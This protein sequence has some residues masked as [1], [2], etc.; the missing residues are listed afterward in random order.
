LAGDETQ[1]ALRTAKLSS[2]GVAN[3][4]YV[5]P[6]ATPYTLTPGEGKYAGSDLFLAP[7]SQLVQ[8]VST[9]VETEAPL[10]TTDL[11]SRVA[12]M[13]SLRAGSRIQARVLEACRV[14]ENAGLIKK[15]GE[16][17]WSGVAQQYSVRSRS[18][19]KIP[20]DRI[21]PEEYREAI[22]AVLAAGHVFTRAQLIT[23]V[24]AVFGFS[25][26]GAVLDEAIGTAIDAMLKDRTLGEASTGIRLRGELAAVLGSQS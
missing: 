19:T 22:R 10:H 3:A 18:G 11:L 23:E 17:Y 5:R 16:F 1:D 15:R 26:T 21:A 9:V 12:G 20:G 2:K 8:E 14:A 24:R 13:W 6:T 4:E 25:R 7:P